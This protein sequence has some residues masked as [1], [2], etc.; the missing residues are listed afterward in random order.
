[1]DAMDSSPSRPAPVPDRDSAEFWHY[2]DK[3]QLALQSCA[4][5]GRL[6][7]FPQ[8]ICPYCRSYEFNWRILSG[9][10]MI[11][12]WTVVHHAHN[13]WFRSQL[14]YIVGVISIAEDPAVRLVMNVVNSAQAALTVGAPVQIVF[15]EV[16]GSSATV[17]AC[18][19]TD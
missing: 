3:R 14:P 16:V 11:A 19:T 1:M 8:P 17:F 6:R 12:S 5:C 9:A 7:Y 15:E 13:P 2:V 18:R 10:G 4:G